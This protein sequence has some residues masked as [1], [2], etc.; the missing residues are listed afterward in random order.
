MFKPLTLLL[1]ML[2]LNAAAQSQENGLLQDVPGD[3]ESPVKYAIYSSAWTESSNAGLRVVAQNQGA[4]EVELVSLLFR[5]ENN[6]SIQ[7]LLE[8]NMTI[9]ALGWAEQELPYVD[10][11]FGSECITNT[12][13]DDWKLVEISNYTLNPSV[14]GLIIED[15][16]SFRIFQCIRPVHVTWAEQDQAHQESQWVMYHYER[17]PL[18]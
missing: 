10:L 5:D 9:P 13:A 2:S 6:P 15:T 7:T 3:N 16:S 14:R 4:Q 11:L 1:A 18:D 12:Q 8:L 17:Q